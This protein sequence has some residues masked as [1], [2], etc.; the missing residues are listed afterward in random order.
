MLTAGHA[1]CV[2]ACPTVCSPSVDAL[3]KA[4]SECA[5]LN[6]DSDLSEG[7]GDFMYNADELRSNMLAQGGDEGDEDE[8]VEGEGYYGQGGDDGAVEYG[9]RDGSSNEAR[10]ASLAMRTGLSAEEIFAD[11]ADEAE[12]QGAEGDVEDE[13]RFAKGKPDDGQAQ[14]ESA[15]QQVEAAAAVGSGQKREREPDAETKQ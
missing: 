7:E 2:R 11:D 1:V 14:L 13:E 12:E 4:V 15:K 6:P 5:A 3:Y 9:M 10:L 8:D